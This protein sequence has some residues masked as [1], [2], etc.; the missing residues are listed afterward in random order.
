MVKPIKTEDQYNKILAR[1]YQLLQIDL[2]ENSVQADEL[3]VLGIL[4]K[5]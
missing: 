4:V 5:V 2:E 3:E 1:V